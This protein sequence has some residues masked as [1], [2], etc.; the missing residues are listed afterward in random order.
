M[1][2]GL[3]K[4]KRLEQ[5]GNGS[6]AIRWLRRQQREFNVLKRI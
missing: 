3:R 1:P 4:N 6:V 2:G 5:N